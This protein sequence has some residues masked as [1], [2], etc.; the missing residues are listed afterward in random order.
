M[1]LRPVPGTP[2]RTAKHMQNLLQTFKTA[3]V[4][5][6]FHNLPP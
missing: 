6:L 4:L 1:G 5:R 3:Q 2:L